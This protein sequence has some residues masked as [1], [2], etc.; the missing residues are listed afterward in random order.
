MI[1]LFRRHLLGYALGEHHDAS[2]MA[3]AQMAV[4][5]RGGDVDGVICAR[6][7]AWSRA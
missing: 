4:A 5:T 2:L 1:A 7:S 3:A 6:A